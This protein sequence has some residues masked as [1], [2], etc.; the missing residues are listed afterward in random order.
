MEK[1]ADIDKFQREKNISNSITRENK[2]RWLTSSDFSVQKIIGPGPKPTDGYHA[3]WSYAEDPHDKLYIIDLGDYSDIVKIQIEWVD[4]NVRGYRVD[5]ATDYRSWYHLPDKSSDSVLQEHDIV[6]TYRRYIRIVLK[7]Q[8]LSLDDIKSVSV[9]ASKSL[10]LPKVPVG[11]GIF[12]YPRPVIV[13][14]PVFVEGVKEPV[15]SLSGYWK[16]T[17]DPPEGFWG[18]GIEYRDWETV[19]VPGCVDAQG[20]A[21]KEREEAVDFHSPAKNFEIVYKKTVSIPK[22]YYGKKVLLRFE[23]AYSY[24][25]IWVEGKMVRIHRSGFTTFDC[26]ITNYAVPG[27]DVLITVGVTAE[28]NTPEFTLPR[29]LLGDVK[30]IC[31]PQQHITRLHMETTF[32]D[33][34]N[35]ATLKVM[36][37]LNL[38]EGKTEG[39]IN[40]IIKDSS[41]KEVF[42]EPSSISFTSS[43]AENEV[44]IHV[45]KPHKW[46]A[47]NPYLY[48]L[49]AVIEEDGKVVQ[50]SVR[51]VGFKSVKVDGN[52]FFVNGEPVKLRGVNWTNINPVAGLSANREHDIESL[53]KLKAANVNYLRTAHFPQYDYFYDLA[54]ELG[55]YVESEVSVHIVT[56]WAPTHFEKY[57]V[58]EDAQY[59]DWYLAEYAEMLEKNRSYTS[60][61]YWSVGNES[62][63]A[64]NFKQGRDYIKRV[65]PS[66]PVKFAWDYSAPK[67]ELD[68]RSVHYPTFPEYDEHHDR[69][70]IYDE[71]AHLYTN[72][73]RI[74]KDPALRDIYGYKIQKHWEGAY[75]QEGA[76]GGAIWHSRDFFIYGPNGIWSFNPKWGLLDTWN[77]EKP[78]YYH[79]KKA[80]SPINIK[81]DRTYEN[82]GAK[83]DLI[84]P[85]ENR[86]NHIN[87]NELIIKW[88]AGE[89]HGVIKGPD[90]KPARKGNILIP[91]RNWSDGDRLY[92]KFIRPN[93]A[94]KDFVVDEYEFVIGGEKAAVLPGP[95]GTAPIMQ[96]NGKEIRVVGKD[97]E[98][99]FDKISG[100]IKSG[101]Y[102][103]TV[104]ITDGPDINL[105]I[106]T[107]P[108][109]WSCNS[110][111]ARQEGN[112]S[113]VTIKGRYGLFDDVSF[114]IGIDGT[115]RMEIGYGMNLP[116]AQ[117][118]ELGVSF[119]L[120]DDID[121]ISWKRRVNL[122]TVYP[123]NHIS[124][125]SGIAYRNRKD[126]EEIYAVKPQ[127]P[128]SL[129]EKEFAFGMNEEN[130]RGTRDF[131]ASKYDFYY[132]EILTKQGF[133]IRAE[134]D[135]MGSVRATPKEDGGVRFVI[136]SEWG[137][138]AVDEFKKY[139]IP[140]C[141]ISGSYANKVVMRFLKKSKK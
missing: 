97:F 118:D 125:L 93:D 4:D 130:W 79:V 30:L 41:G 129:D 28:A 83:K 119:N 20:L 78:E 34:Y 58:R 44:F 80:Y 51:R 65:D 60:I 48:T 102:D 35:N 132:A 113:I 18:N 7:E 64:Y 137:S 141:V 91:A 109:E 31:L 100:R 127:W 15:V 133:G 88:I 23:S 89:D 62:D 114:E 112:Q 120:T 126:G 9:L 50:R 55:F 76:M 101:S 140:L 75:N 131:R 33:N 134:S 38:P 39:S 84:L 47:E 12:G 42:I 25:R 87:L 72:C 40:L 56:R 14:L 66:R 8:S 116:D 57:D 122:W 115:G 22:E 69:P 108:S 85:V 53:L 117:F 21:V 5:V 103:D 43:N 138:T 27:N 124:R 16:F 61:I 106:D 99:V 81:E 59:T 71:Y 2:K 104:V 123:E 135:G 107:T 70:T 45:D 96:E 105:G 13:P 54:D 98:I 74:E 24:A 46:N 3:D 121:S 29:G 52:I 110:I 26:D 68:I 82:P 11:P 139:D 37:G 19:L 95:S 36:G 6:E 1:K 94:I 136:N 67:E 128:W 10:P 111:S 73:A 32:D 90:I 49:E 63:W 86:Y 77:R 17:K 92:L